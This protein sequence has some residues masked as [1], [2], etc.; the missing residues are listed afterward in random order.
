MNQASEIFTVPARR[1]PVRRL[2]DEMG[3]YLVIAELV[4]IIGELEERAEGGENYRWARCGE[5]LK[6]AKQHA[7]EHW[8]DNE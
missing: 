8:R 1:T 7:D 5:G 6:L 2:V 4:D 3:P